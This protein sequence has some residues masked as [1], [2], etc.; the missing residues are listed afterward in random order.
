MRLRMALNFF[1]L[2]GIRAHEIF[3][4]EEIFD[5]RLRDNFVHSIVSAE[6]LGATLPFS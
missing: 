2:D 5:H 1:S 3:K 6:G 4:F